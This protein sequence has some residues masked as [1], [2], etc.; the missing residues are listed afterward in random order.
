MRYLVVTAFGELTHRPFAGLAGVGDDRPHAR[1]LEQDAFA[2]AV[3]RDLYVASVEPGHH[4]GDDGQSG[5]DDVGA[6]R[7]QSL[8][9]PPLI[10]LHGVKHLEQVLDITAWNPRGVD[11]AR[12]E[13]A[14]PR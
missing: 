10:R 9:A 2:N 5:D 1:C 6:V 11:A 13:D 4:F 12:R 14:L 3:A 8:D 7:I